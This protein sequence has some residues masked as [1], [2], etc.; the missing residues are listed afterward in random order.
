MLGK[1]SACT[2]RR[3]LFEPPAVNA[4]RVDTR[5]MPGIP[6]RRVAGG[7]MATPSGKRHV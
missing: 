3:A 2:N 4:N 5:D 1:C 7:Y 6:V